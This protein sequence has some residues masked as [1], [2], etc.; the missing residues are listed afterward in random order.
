MRDPDDER[1]AHA[2]GALLVRHADVR[3]ALRETLKLIELVGNEAAEPAI[4]ILD[5]MRAPGSRPPPSL[6]RIVRAGTSN[7]SGNAM[8]PS[9][10]RYSKPVRL[11]T[12]GS[13][14]LDFW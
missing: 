11:F 9:E 1:V 13:L 6:V 12:R 5:D 2:E 3:P 4:C 10:Y 7:G 14:L 8:A